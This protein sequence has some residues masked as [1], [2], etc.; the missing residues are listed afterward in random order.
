ML[1]PELLNVRV[2]KI[3]MEAKGVISIQL[4]GNG[5]GPLPQFSP[6]AHIDLHLSNGFPDQH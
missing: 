2:G 5:H 1:M 4:V 6:G 3:E